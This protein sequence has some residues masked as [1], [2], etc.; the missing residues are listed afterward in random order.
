MFLDELDIAGTISS[1]LKSVAIMKLPYPAD[2]CPFPRVIEFF[3]ENAKN[4]S[5]FI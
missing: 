4:L 2:F 1:I 5:P 3:V